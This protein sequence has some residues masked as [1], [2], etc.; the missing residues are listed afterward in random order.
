MA[1]QAMEMCNRCVATLVVNFNVLSR[2]AQS[3]HLG[4]EAASIVYLS[5]CLISAFQR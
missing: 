3:M 2:T 4:R 1:I 5:D